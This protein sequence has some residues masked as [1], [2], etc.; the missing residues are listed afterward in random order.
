MKQ[1]NETNQW[2]KS[3]KQINETNQWNKSMKQINDTN[4][5]NKSMK[6]INDFGVD[7]RIDIIKKRMIFWELI[8]LNRVKITTKLLKYKNHF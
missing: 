3:M 7:L 5:W 2:Y 8:W 6:Q 1:I 4:Q